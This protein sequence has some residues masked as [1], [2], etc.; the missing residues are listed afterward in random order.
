MFLC[1]GE[2]M[3]RLAPEEFLRLGQ[4]LPGNLQATFGGSEAN[5]A[6]SLAM[7][8]HDVRYVTAM[9]DNAI[10]DALVAH[11][12]SF[13]IDMRFCLRKKEGRLG[14]YFL[15]TGANQ[16]SSVV[17]YDRQ[18]SSISS[19]TPE[20]YS[21]EKALDGV[22]GVHI[23]GITPAV[24]EQAYLST[25]ALV[26]LAEKQ[27]AQVSCDLNFRNKLWNWK[28]GVST[29]ELAGECMSKILP[30]VSLLIANEEDSKDVLNIEAEGTSVEEGEINAEAYVE[31][32]RKIV[33]RFPNIHTIAFTLRESYSASHNNWGGMLY[34]AKQDKAHFAPLDDEGNYQPY[35]IKNI[36]DRVG[37][38][39]SFAAGLLHAFTSDNYNEPADAL[40]YAVAASC[41]N[42]SIKGDFNFVTEPEVAALA[43]GSA[44][45]R[46]R[47]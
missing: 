33:E 47:R 20:E 32:A 35:E 29:R 21:F 8:Q 22:N 4:S 34:D 2:V 41:L 6:V 44:S 38:G 28:P 39:D 12:R 16:R 5:V 19:A 40:R 7:F 9:P 27:G 26:E 25:L 15:E 17:T 43:E 45:G 14:V 37:G 46:V 18:H 10:S 3:L 30:Y 36:V 31:V 24:S 1:H 42:H 11:L 13:G 23:S